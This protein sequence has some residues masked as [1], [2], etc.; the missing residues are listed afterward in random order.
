MNNRFD[1]FEIEFHEGH[2]NVT[3]LIK[4]AANVPDDAPETLKTVVQN[5]EINFNDKNAQVM[6]LLDKYQEQGVQFLDS[7]R[8]DIM[9]TFDTFIS[10]VNAA[11]ESSGSSAA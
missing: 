6:A 5:F 2:E 10:D 11:K 1:S 4:D 9:E 8:K 7:V 3:E